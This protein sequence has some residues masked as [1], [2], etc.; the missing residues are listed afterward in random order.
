M[1]VD[2]RL[3]TVTTCVRIQPVGR[4]YVIFARPALTPLT[5]P[6]PDT[7]ATDALPVLHVP[8]P[9]K[10]YNVVVLPSHTL[11]VPVI[12]TGSGFTVT[13]AVR[14]QPVP[15]VYVIVALP[16]LA[17]LTS[18]LTLTVATDVLLLLHVPPPSVLLRV[19]TSP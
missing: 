1:I 19:L 3:F 18:P 8:L 11:A 14:R 15:N 13:D 4:V 7:V 12:T 2:G 16:A 5:S 6:L 17:P 9:L 10:L